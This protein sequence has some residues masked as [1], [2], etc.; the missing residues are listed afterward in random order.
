MMALTFG[1]PTDFVHEIKGLLEV[2]EFILAGE[3]MFLY[4]R[5][6]R[7]AGVKFFQCFPFERRNAATAGNALFV[8]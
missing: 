4:D 7:D 6:L 3:V 5:P 1:Q 2:G 8:G